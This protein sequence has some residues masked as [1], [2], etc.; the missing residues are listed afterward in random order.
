MIDTNYL[1]SLIVQLDRFSRSSNS[2]VTPSDLDN[3]VNH[4]VRVLNAFVDE[5]EKDQSNS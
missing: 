2:S 1:R 3:L 4:L 5:V